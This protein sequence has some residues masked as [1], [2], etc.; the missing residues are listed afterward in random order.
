[1]DFANFKLAIL[2]ILG[3]ASFNKVDGKESLSADECAKLK[4]YG[5]SDKFLAD[6]NAYLAKPEPS[7]KQANDNH[8]MAA[9][10]A[11]LG[12]VTEQLQAAT[13]ELNSLKAANAQDKAAHDAA[14]K[15]KEQEIATLNDKVK[16]LAALPENDPGKGAGNGAAPAASFNLD[17]TAQLGGLQGEMFSLSRPYNLRARAAL[18]ANNGQYLAVA[19]PNSVDYKSLQDDLGA[20]Y[21]TRWS[22][23]LQSFLVELP[24]ITKLFPTESG[25]QDLDTLV[26]LWLGEFSQPDNSADSD[27]DKVSKGSYEFGHETLRM[28]DVMFAHKFKSLKALEKSWI[29]YLNR[30]GSNPVK[31][32]FIEYLL[33]ETAK[34]LH[35]ERELRWVN[36]VRK[37]PN[38]NVPGKAM[39]A[40][41]GLYEYL[42]KRVEGHTDFTPDGGTTGNTV[43]QIKPFEL[44]E[45]TP[46]NIGEV[47]YLGT[48]M[49]P[50]VF[51]DTGKMVLY[52]PSFMLPW[53][54]KYNETH[55]GQNTDYK[56]G[57]NYVKEYPSVKIVTIPNADNHHRIFWTIEGNIKTYDHVAG[58]M[59]RFTLEQQDWS[60]KVWSN[61]KEGIAAEAVGYKYTDKALMDGSRQLIWCNQY[62]RPSTYFIEADRDANPS[63][64]LHCSIVTVANTKVYTITDIADAPMGQVVSLK[65]GADGDNGVTIK[66][67]GKFELL[68]AD[69]T[70]DRGDIIRLMKRADGKFVEIE[71]TTAVAD[72]YQFP[73]DATAPSVAGATV[74][75]TSENTKATAITDLAD[76]VVGT[77]YTIHGA[78]KENA[79]TIAN[80][81]KFV[82][83]KDIT[84]EA[85]KFIRLVKAADGKFYEIARG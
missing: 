71:R 33:V 29:G 37:N 38:P 18:L 36:G 59:L 30:E 35:N 43:Y 72:S 3:L 8:Q 27:F 64:L 31:L 78:G 5:F 19:T 56:A 58:E 2:G 22:D 51:R 20:F 39:E 68:S 44:P 66:K 10:A 47:F 63:A 40:A 46:G 60:M 79:S 82:L 11:V 55:Y 23:R 42:R 41:D 13:A 80:A 28:Y 34:A 53:Y 84:L 45:I 77:T 50:S 65:C 14:I 32:S 25:H 16:T 85:G 4:E 24:T 62:D 73:A 75:I 54:H 74:F 21:R 76:A 61:W 48:G 15:A 83:T 49:I 9:V 6:F 52:I 70:P 81:G 67:E 12:Q 57:I 26:N 1:M 17:D 7:A 69:W